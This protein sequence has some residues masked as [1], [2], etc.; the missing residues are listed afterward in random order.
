MHALG[1]Y[2]CLF[3]YLNFFS[4]HFV[5]ISVHQMNGVFLLFVHLINTFWV[6]INRLQSHMLMQKLEL[7]VINTT[8]FL[9]QSAVLA[10]Y[11]MSIFQIQS[12]CLSASAYEG[13][14]INESW[15]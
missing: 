1:T 8:L 13:V 7:V 5:T 2:V 12:Y 15:V 6:K 10:A 14:E 4:A 3:I 11:F 9:K